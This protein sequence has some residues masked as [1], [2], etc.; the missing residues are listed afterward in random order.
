M[1]FESLKLP[2]P[3]LHRSSAQFPAA[4]PAPAEAIN[5]VR[6]LNQAYIDAAREGDADWFERHM[7]DEVLVIMGS[8]RRLRKSEFVEKVRSEPTDY[9]SLTMN[10]ANIRTFG[11]IVQVDA[12]APY[13]LGNGTRGI[14]R[15]ID[16]WAWMGGRWQ[17]ISAQITPLPGEGA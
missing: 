14:S 13:E 9:R 3:S 15:Y 4:E 17:V 12:D 11:S 1:N 10:S 5:A 16:T 2:R 6:E 8:G 7:A